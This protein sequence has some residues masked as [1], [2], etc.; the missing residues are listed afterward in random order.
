MAK[1]TAD[2][3]ARPKLHGVTTLT[4]LAGAGVVVQDRSSDVNPDRVALLVGDTAAHVVFDGTLAEV[5]ALLVE[6]ALQLS[7]LRDAR[8]DERMG[9]SA[10]R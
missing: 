6:A 1:D 4:Q 10:H 8:I 9:W 2:A 3:V 5:E 7:Q